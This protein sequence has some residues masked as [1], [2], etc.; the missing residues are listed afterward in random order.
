MRTSLSFDQNVSSKTIKQALCIVSKG[1]G[2]MIRKACSGEHFFVGGSTYD[3][4][5]IIIM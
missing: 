2:I 5:S 3:Y 1:R 4:I